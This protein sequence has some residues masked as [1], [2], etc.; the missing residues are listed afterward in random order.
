STVFTA[1]SESIV[2][3]LAGFFDAELYPGVELSICPAT[4]T[5]DMH[6]WFPMYFPIQRPLTVDAG[7]EI[8][9]HMW[10]RSSGAKTWYEWCIDTS[11]SSG[12]HNV[13][14][15]EFWIGQ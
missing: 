15:H 7:A 9:V 6:S 2:H 3:G 14:G 8:S 13:N 4:H 5:P 11:D 10:R 1:R 12:I